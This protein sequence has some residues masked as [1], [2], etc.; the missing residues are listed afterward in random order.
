MSGTA[1]TT[2]FPGMVDGRVK[3]LQTRVHGGILHIRDNAEHQWTSKEHKI[4][5]IDMVVCNLYPFEATLA[6]LPSPSGRGVGG[7]DEAVGVRP[8]HP[9]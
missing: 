6:K 9:R 3:T 4:L 5:P 7:R 2:G 1:E 8:K